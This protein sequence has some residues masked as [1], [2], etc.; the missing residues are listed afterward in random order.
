MVP[1]KKLD[2]FILAKFMLTFAGAFVVCLFVFMMQFTW[3]YV[4]ELVG[5]GLS[6]DILGRFFWYMGVTL[7]PTALP[8]A[9]LLAALITF[10]NMGEQLELLAM[11]AAGVSLVRIMSPVLCV[12][13]VFAGLSFYFQNHTS[14]RAQISLRTLLFSMKQSSP[15]VEIPEGVFYSGVPNVNL[16]VQR[17]DAAT[18]MLYQLII[19]KTDQGFDRA[20]ILLADSGRM[21]M[22][23]DKM[24]LRLDLWKGE[25]FENLQ[26]RNF[27]AL[28]SGSVPYDRETFEFKQILI[29]FDSNFNLMDEE[30]LRGMPS[31]KDMARIEQDVD[32]VEQRMDSVGRAYYRTARAAHLAK[33]SLSRADARRLAE[34]VRTRPPVFDSLYAGLPP[35]RQVSALQRAASGARAMTTDLEWKSAVTAEGDLYIRRHW[36]EWH[37]KMTLS[38]ACL[39]FFFVGAPLGAIIRKGGLGMPTVVSVLIF[40]FYYIINTSGMKMARDG[41]WNMVYG[42]WVS[43]AV[44]LPFGAFL[45][46]KANKDSVVF[47]LEAYVA[48][49]RRLLG[50]RA[51]RHVFRKE[52]IIDDP[53]YARL[54]PEIAALREDCRAYAA[55][56][57][58][59]LA[60]NYVRVFFRYAPDSRVEEIGDRMEAVIEELAN[61]RDARILQELGNLPFIYVR[62]HTSPFHSRRLNVAAGILFPVGLALWLRIWRFRLRLLRDMRQVVKSCDALEAL[63]KAHAGP[64]GPEGRA[65]GAGQGKTESETIHT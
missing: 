19:Y 62:A 23:A 43:S 24:H 34:A 11:K 26:A 50:L 57:R 22:T 8:L 60:P 42:M 49:L 55:A 52:V 21:E 13:V 40:I 25:Q 58:L 31:A 64:A 9:V 33:P 47:N 51:K 16:Y 54:V 18:G 28:Q 39:F 10:G 36:V 63:V 2:R 32:S 1:I 46:Y 6:I 27:S 12:V 44:L 5:K 35:D 48:A 37:Q 56:H 65:D 17:K 3:R 30:M 15:A 59:Y 20:Q 7:V 41:S 38:L 4:D 14:P 29:D 61:S 45:T 53:G